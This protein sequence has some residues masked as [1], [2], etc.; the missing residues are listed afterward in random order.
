[1]S[2]PNRCSNDFKIKNFP[3]QKE[4]IVADKIV[5]N[6]NVSQEG[7][8][9]LNLDPTTLSKLPKIQTGSSSIGDNPTAVTDA[10]TAGILKQGDLFIATAPGVTV[11]IMQIVQ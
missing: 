6:L 5:T 8:A 10:V 11:G 9:L 3:D 7:F 2:C 4:C 1:M